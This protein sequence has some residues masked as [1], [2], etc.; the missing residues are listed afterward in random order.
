VKTFLL[1]EGES[2]DDE[3]NICFAFRNLLPGNNDIFTN[4][5]THAGAKAEAK[6]AG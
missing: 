6:A 5:H 2:A 3:E 4:A 1:P